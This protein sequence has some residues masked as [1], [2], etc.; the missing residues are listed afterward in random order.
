M[1]PGD[2]LQADADLSFTPHVPTHRT[3]C[4][5]T[6]SL[7]IQDTITP[8]SGPR[9]TKIMGIL[10]PSAFG[11][12]PS[13]I[14]LGARPKAKR[15]EGLLARLSMGVA[16]GSPMKAGGSPKL[17][18]GAGSPLKGAGAKGTSVKVWP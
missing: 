6:A 10:E 18:G 2:P 5:Q 1:A 4:P 13:R 17:A 15:P 12:G 14:S 11:M 7:S 3:L 16:G 9:L 8:V